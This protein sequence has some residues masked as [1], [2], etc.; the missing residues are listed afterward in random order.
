MRALPAYFAALFLTL[1]AVPALALP[2]LTLPSGTS[3]P[4]LDPLADSATWAGAASVSLPWDVQS[5]KPMGESTVVRI[6]TDG[7]D[8]T[9]R[10]VS[11]NKRITGH[12]PFVV[13]H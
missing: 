2:Q 4:P 13:Q 5:A 10:F 6:A 9:H 3:G 11:G 12:S 1:W 8:L 7:R